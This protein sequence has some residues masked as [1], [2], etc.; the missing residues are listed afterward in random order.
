MS[1]LTI[2]YTIEDALK[3][4]EK[5]TS[6]IKYVS[7]YIGNYLQTRQQFYCTYDDFMNAVGDQSIFNISWSWDIKFVADDWWITWD[8]RGE[9]IMHCIPTQPRKY[10]VPEAHLLINTIIDEDV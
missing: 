10:R 2:K 1:Q 6:D 4:H 9:W 3:K 5:N 8:S 7:Y